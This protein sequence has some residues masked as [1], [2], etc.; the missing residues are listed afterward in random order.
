VHVLVLACVL[1]LLPVAALAQTAPSG[2]GLTEV[3]SERDRAEARVG[4]LRAEEVDARARLVQV[5][6]ELAAAEADLA[7]AV[8]ALEEAEA[9]LA[10]ADAAAAAARTRLAEV[11]VELEE[12]EAALA[13]AIGKLE[14]RVVAAFKYG[15]VSFAEAFSGVRDFNDF[16]TSTTMVAHVL[17]GDRVMVTEVQGLF[18][19]VEDQRAE[20][21]A[22]RATAEQEREAAAAAAARIETAARDEERSLERIAEQRDEREQLFLEL[23]DDR[24]AAEGH[25]A[26][27]EAESARI[28]DQLAEIARQQVAAA[29]AEQAR[30][31]QEAAAAAA[32]AA[33]EQARQ[34]RE[35]AQQPSEPT[36]AEPTPDDPNPAAPEDGSGAGEGEA[37]EGGADD[38]GAD[39]AEPPPP[40]PPTT[41]PPPVATGW[42]RPVPGI[43]T[44]PFGPRWGAMHNGVDLRGD[45]GTTVVAAQPGIVVTAINVC[46]PTSSWGCGGGFG[47]YV[48][49]VHANGLA[50]IYA[51]LSATAV[52]IGQ[53]VSAGQAVGLVGNSGNSYGPHL[54]LEVRLAGV[55]QNPCGYI[56]C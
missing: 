22:L 54:H 33:A 11:R 55:P 32:A 29:A 38:G 49:V 20:A 36:P 45:V 21:Q 43:V 16:M 39:E 48:T 2:R 12:T 26:G 5:E 17:D 40:P 51:H 50:T 42:V 25:L 9:A 6:E 7:R 52:G 18:A 28:A 35:A 44:S 14:S 27:L 53:Q 4:Q 46:H 19:A 15:Q 10:A 3:A 37:S 41:T 8:A 30:L 47:N 34:E 1:S 24:A 56:P 31:A 13:L 23:R